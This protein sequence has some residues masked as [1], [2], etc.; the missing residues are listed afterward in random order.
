MSRCERFASYASSS[1][2][3][4]NNSTGVTQ[5]TDEVYASSEGNCINSTCVTQNTD[6]VVNSKY[7]N[8]TTGSQST[9]RA[10]GNLG[11]EVQND[12][13]AISNREEK[14]VGE[15]GPNKNVENGTNE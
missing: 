13:K 9:G 1:E 14:R 5:N 15:H 7:L 3:N 2:G 8:R 4:C 11:T 12:G 6:E 10:A